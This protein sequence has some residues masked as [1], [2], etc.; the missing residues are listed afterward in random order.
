MDKA[1]DAFRTISEVA[2]LLETPAHVLR[3]WESRFPQIKPVKRAGGRRY[4]RPAD[5]ALLSG[6]RRLLHDEGMT[7]RGVQKILREQGVRH[8]SGLT[9]EEDAALEMIEDVEEDVIASQPIQ[10]FPQAR[11]GVDAE[12]SP[13][14][15]IPVDEAASPVATSPKEAEPVELAPE[16][17]AKPASPQPLTTEGKDEA[18]EVAVAP[19]VADKVYD[20]A[21][22]GP[23]PAHQ[24]L[25][26][27]VPE[28]PVA[29][30]PAAVKNIFVDHPELP[31]DLPPVARALPPK[32]V[33]VADQEAS[34]D[35]DLRS[36]PLPD[37]GPD[38]SP[39]DS[40][41]VASKLDKTAVDT[42]EAAAQQTEEPIAA[43]DAEMPDQA[44]DDRDAIISDV[45]HPAP[46]PPPATPAPAATLPQAPGPSEA[47]P[48]TD[49]AAHW[50]AADLRALRHDAFVGHLPQATALAQRLEALRDHVGDRGRVPRR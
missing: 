23:V 35:A 3:F 9:E 40:D 47:D 44:V 17:S 27:E 28:V 8:V 49:P 11:D 21:L 33:D 5:M 50:L 13:D 10:L 4:Y 31:L 19:V 22:P 43:Q 36:Q 15:D 25:A 46:S 37:A 18:D 14:A 42:N 1:P 20:Q 41:N 7:I 24:P 26:N 6:I 2:E 34:S 48:V 29:A 12:E 16:P 32:P 45:T 39:S 30:P 38:L